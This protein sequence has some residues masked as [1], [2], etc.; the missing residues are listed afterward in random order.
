MSPDTE[1]IA[2]VRAWANALRRAGYVEMTSV[3]LTEFLSDLADGLVTAMAADPF[4]EQPGYDVGVALVRARLSTPSSLSSSMTILA[5]LPGLAGCSDAAARSRA[6]RLLAAMSEGFTQALQQRILTEQE[7]IQLAARR[8]LVEAQHGWQRSQAQL[9]AVFDGAG[10]AIAICALDGDLIQVN[11]ALA[12]MVGRPIGSLPG[13]PFLDL[14]HPGDQASTR[15]AMLELSGTASRHVRLEKRFIR[16]DGT[17]GWA[18]LSVSVVPDADDRAVNLVVVGEDVTVQ[19]HLQRQLRHQAH[20]DGL[21]GLPNR[22]L[23]YQQLAETL[24]TAPAGSRVGVCFVD[25]DEFKA[26]N[27]TL[28]HSMGDRLLIAVASRLTDSLDPDEHFLARVG[29]DEF[30]VIVRTSRGPT[31]LARLADRMLAA[32]AAPI[33]I[34][35]Y[36][37]AV[38]ASIGIAEEIAGHTDPQ[39]LLRAADATMYLA[40]ADGRHRW[41]MFD[42]VRHAEQVNRYEMISELPQALDRDEFLV[43]YQPI[44]SLADGTLQG[45]EALLRWYRPRTGVV[46][47]NTFIPVAEQ[48]GL[49]V[50]L[51]R[52]VLR[53]ACR[54]ASSWQRAPGRQP[55]ISVNVSMRQ[56]AE[57]GLVSDVTGALD[58]AGLNPADLQLELTE[59]AVMVPS[60]SCV[61]TLRLIAD[62][63]VRIAIDDFGIGYSNLAHLRHLPIHGLKLAGAFM[64]GIRTPGPDRV[65]E[66][67]VGT[68]IELAHTLGLTVT[69]EGV[70]NADQAARLAALGCD[71]A[72]GWQYGAAGPSSAIENQLGGAARPRPAVRRGPR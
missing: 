22:E 63:G 24:R 29:G 27:D 67:I 44:V 20:H 43:H 11:R 2:L 18:A 50:P 48:S 16:Q 35:A 25:L 58:D 30:A 39:Q 3:R 62:L 65:D 60:D 32:L 70:E 15:A 46:S 57:P 14:I 37:L 38:S 26:I 68:I 9:E 55:F 13:S 59:T 45:A 4:R 42:P 7:A 56:C 66:Q 41:A 71:L 53:E 69:A 28:G 19:H 8:A 6:D 40:K 34:D 5:G 1:M 64:A 61:A 33:R 21:T 31:E 23:L 47:P 54:Q 51:G 10:T 36:R 72:Q 17:V 52:W 12:D 49:I